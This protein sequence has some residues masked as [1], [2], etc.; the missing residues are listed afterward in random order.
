MDV[1]DTLQNHGKRL[2]HL[3]GLEAADT[4]VYRY[5]IWVIPGPGVGAVGQIPIPWNCTVTEI[6]ANVQDGI[7][8]DFN[9]EHR[10]TAGVA[11]IDIL[12]GDMEADTDGETISSGF[13]ETSLVKDNYLTVAI[14]A[15]GGAVT[16]LTIRLKVRI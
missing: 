5:F 12:P 1:G 6:K 15:I 7:S 14:S 9:I 3:E 2:R 16:D 10:D 4:L 13:D 8:A 11:G